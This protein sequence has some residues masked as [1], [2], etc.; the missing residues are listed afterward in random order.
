MIIQLQVALQKA[1]GC[2]LAPDLTPHGDS[3]TYSTYM[4]EIYSPSK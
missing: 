4:D 1:A 3:D 2:L